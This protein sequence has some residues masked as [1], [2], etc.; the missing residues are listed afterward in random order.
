M[1]G[2]IDQEI[3]WSSGGG[4]GQKTDEQTLRPCATFASQR[5]GF[6]ESKAEASCTNQVSADAGVTVDDVDAALDDADVRAALATGQQFYGDRGVADAGSFNIA[7]GTA[8]LSLSEAT[9]TQAGPNCTPVPSGIAALQAVLQA[10]SE[11]Q[12]A[13]PG[14]AGK[15]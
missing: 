2:C 10:L 1:P 11:R 6:L 5:F 4:F 13:L 9:C 14:C 8:R 3:S 15:F 12:R 7:V